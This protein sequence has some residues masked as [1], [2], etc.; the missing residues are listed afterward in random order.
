M[1]RTT[2]SDLFQ[3]KIATIRRNLKKKF[4]PL[5]EIKEEITNFGD[6]K[7]VFFAT[8]D[9]SRTCFRREYV[10]AIQR[11]FK[12]IELWMSQEIENRRDG[13]ISRLLVGKLPWNHYVILAP[14]IKQDESKEK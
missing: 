4:K 12:S 8:E 7:Y 14:N 1:T 2:L 3:F 9:G 6:E 11:S 10:E 13:D 5:L